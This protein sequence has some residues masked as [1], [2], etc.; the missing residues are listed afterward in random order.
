MSGLK[1]YTGMRFGKLVVI[2]QVS[3]RRSCRAIHRQ[4]LCKC[5]C[6]NE[7]TPWMS[8]LKAGATISCGCHRKQV[9]INSN[10]THGM[11]NT[12]TYITWDGM[13]QRCTNKKNDSYYKYGGVGIKVCEEWL[14]FENFLMDMGIRP[15]GTSLDRINGSKGYYK[16]NCRWADIY[17]QNFNVSKRKDKYVSEYKGVGRTGNKWNVQVKGIHVGVFDTEIEAAK[18]YDAVAINFSGSKLNFPLEKVT[19][20]DYSTFKKPR[21]Y[22]LTEENVEEI[23]KSN[24]PTR[25]FMEKFC[26]SKK[27]V[28]EI[29]RG[30]AWR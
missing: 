24:L 10:I 15:E 3:E 8:S 6:G 5:D 1:D 13:I 20:A 17:T 22:K 23:R 9:L 11:T 19:P 29:K 12:P 26:V 4:F 18:A 14:S 21:G 30:N 2:K 27:L 25:Y 16:E 7:S 28:N